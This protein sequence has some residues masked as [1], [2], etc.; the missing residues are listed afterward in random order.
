M[1]YFAY[2]SNMS[3]QRL[4]QR[5][6]SARALGAHS[7]PGHTL[8]FHKTGRDGSGKC[9]AFYTGASHDVVLGVLYHLAEHEKAALD[10]AEGLGIGYREASIEVYSGAGRAEPCFSYFAL[11]IDPTLAPYSWYKQHVLIGARE[12]GLPGEY[13]ADIERV[14]AII[15]PNQQRAAEQF[16]IHQ[17]K[18]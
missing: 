1:K 12:A 2:G 15:D 9:D 16:A 7:L 6:P 10:R 8:R 18:N 11:R 5:T 17:Q 14:A 13:L 4:L 3:L